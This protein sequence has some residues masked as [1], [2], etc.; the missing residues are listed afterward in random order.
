MTVEKQELEQVV[1]GFHEATEKVKQVEVHLTDEVKK[2]VASSENAQKSADSALKKAQEVADDVFALT[3][4]FD[5]I[6]M[7]DETPVQRKTAGALLVEKIKSA[8]DARSASNFSITV[9]V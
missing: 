6:G 7:Y 8:G 5:R 3:Q 2:S 1:K 4:K 9:E